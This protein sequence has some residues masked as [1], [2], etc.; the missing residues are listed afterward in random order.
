M[1]SPLRI[2]LLPIVIT[3]HIYKKKKL[4]KR[5]N[6]WKMAAEANLDEFLNKYTEY[7]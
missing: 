6:T 1:F 7:S 5:E 2:V 4:A 3:L